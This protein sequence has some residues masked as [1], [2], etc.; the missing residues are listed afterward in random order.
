MKLAMREAIIGFRRAP[1][2]SALSITTIGFSL[3]AFGL[4]SLVAHNIRNTLKDVESRVEIRAFI[5]EG[6]PV[7][8]IADAMGVIGNYPEVQ[9]VEYV[10]P[11]QALERARKELGEFQDVFEGQFLPRFQPV[12]VSAPLA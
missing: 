11:E 5:D 7:E 12:A 1:L 10:T 9:R 3:F 2:L 6:S 8:P 4:F